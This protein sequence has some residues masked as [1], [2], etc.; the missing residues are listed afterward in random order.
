VIPIIGIILGKLSGQFELTALVA[1]IASLILIPVEI[2][3]TWGA[4]QVFQRETILTRW[5]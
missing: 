3:S 1:V 4:A 5:K 2:L